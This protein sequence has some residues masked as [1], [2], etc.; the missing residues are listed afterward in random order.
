MSPDGKWVVMIAG[1]EGRQNLYA[2]SL[3]ELAKERPVA[4]QLTSTSAGKSS[5][6]I[7]P[8]SKEVFY[9]EGGRIRVVPIERGEGRALGVTAEMDVPFDREKMEVFHEAWTLQRD[10]FYDPAY[11]GADWEA[12]RRRS[13]R[14]S[15]APAT[16]DEMRRLLSLMIGE[17]NASH[18]GVGA[19]G[20][21]PPETG[22]LGLRFDA[23]EYE[24]NGRLRITEVVA[25][26]PAAVTRQI[27]V[28]DYLL[29][30]DGAAVGR[31]VNLDA[32]LDHTIGK[33]VALTVSAA[34][35]GAS[36]REV[37]VKPVSRND[38]KGCCTGSGSSRTAPTSSRRA[39]GA[40]AT[41]TC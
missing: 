34:S 40:S 22:R 26:G 2:Y 14:R 36:P 38:E 15:P 41:C 28:G 32:R 12:V 29:A 23:G 33:R 18:L 10:N 21:T 17:L 13:S 6:Q 9:L 35:D 7:T 4:R 20:S 39:A 19:P 25:L 3:D 11:H 30:V 27:H 5:L 16:P 1:A 8:D 24:Q 31:G 37:A